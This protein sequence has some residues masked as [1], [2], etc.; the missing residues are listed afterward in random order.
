MRC[1]KCKKKATGRV[2]TFDGA[3]SWY[4]YFCIKCDTEW[5][6]RKPIDPVVFLDLLEAA[7]NTEPYGDEVIRNII[8]YLKGDRGPLERLAN[9][10]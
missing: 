2:Q 9:K 3:T 10:K 6:L 5:Y 7:W 8:K 4:A 1:P